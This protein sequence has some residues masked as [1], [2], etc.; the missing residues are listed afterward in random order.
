MDETIIYIDKQESLASVVDKLKQAETEAVIIIAPHRATVLNSLVNLK[1]LRAQAEAIKRQLTLVTEDG[2]GRA[3]GRQAG[4]NVSEFLPGGNNPQLADQLRVESLPPLVQEFDLVYK[5]PVG[6]APRPAT[7]WQIPTI[8]IPWRWRG[9]SSKVIALYG[10]SL[11]IV[12]VAGILLIPQAKVNLTVA[13]QLL[14]VKL[15]LQMADLSISNQSNSSIISGRFIDTL[16]SLDK[17]FPTTGTRNEGEKARGEIIIYN[18]SGIMAGL[19]ADTRFSAG[20][21]IFKIPADVLIGPGSGSKPASARALVVAESGGAEGNLKAN[22]KLIVPGLSGALRDLIYA[23]VASGFSGG[24]DKKIG[25]V[26]EQDIVNAKE[27][28][29]RSVRTESLKKLNKQLKRNEQIYPD[30]VQVDIIEAVPSKKAGDESKDFNLRVQVRAWSLALP[31]DTIEKT[32]TDYVKTQTGQ[33]VEPTPQMRSDVNLGITASDFLKRLISFDL[34]TEGVVYRP[35]DLNKLSSQIKFK[36]KLKA[37]EILT[38]IENVR[39]TNIAIWPNWSN[40]LPF[41]TSNI[42]WQL[43]FI[44]L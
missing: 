4:L 20:N 3:L 16:Q 27:S 34:T 9:F 40:R 12:L 41:L 25:V 18:H 37:E 28:I 43:N 35:L 17:T 22:T 33:S 44:K 32:L 7:A 38:G 1:I 23:E 29:S 10:L 19:K 13:G 6:P 21:L 31:R 26:S 11:L 5:Q 15:P 24:T 14:Q 30:L 42:K 39:Q 36:N 8:H 2:N